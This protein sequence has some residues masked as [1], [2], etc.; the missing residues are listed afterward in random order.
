M[1]LPLLTRYNDT[2]RYDR[3]QGVVLVA[4]WRRYPDR[5]QAAEFRAAEAIAHSLSEWAV[6]SQSAAY[7]AGYALALAARA[8]A[9]RPSEARRAAIIQAGEMLRHARPS[10]H[11]LARMLEEGLARADTTILA[12]GDAEASLLD[13]VGGAVT[14]ADRV[15][16]RCGRLAAGLLD[17][18][19]HVLTHGYAGPALT[20]ALALAHAE[21]QKQ[22]RITV[23][24]PR[25]G[26]DRAR[27]AAALANAIGVAVTL[28]RDAAPE[29]GFADA[30]Y[31]VMFL[32]AER[33]ALDGAMAGASGCAAYVAAARQHGVPCYILGYDGPDPTC[34]T[35]ASLAADGTTDDA[36][37]PPEQISAIITSRGIYRP[38]MVRRFLGDGDAPIDV[39]PL[40]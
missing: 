14:R 27:L 26:L 20:W 4:D 21:E 1:Q 32:G 6:D 40:S 31:Q 25:A 12:G 17:E 35:A 33:I 13:Y 3:T 29:P 30:A 19:D 7:M 2:V 18:G 24:T 23:A 15:A 37:V 28:R 8:W 5:S 36:V 22:V 34:P 16:E 38:E 11:R 39:I 10:D 9:S